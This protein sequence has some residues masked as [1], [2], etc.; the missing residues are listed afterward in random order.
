[1]DDSTND[2]LKR[3]YALSEATR[4]IN[5]CE[6]ADDV[7]T[8]AQKYYAFLNGGAVSAPATKEPAASV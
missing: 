3:Q 6:C 7:V 2:L 1:M 4:A 8:R 5:S